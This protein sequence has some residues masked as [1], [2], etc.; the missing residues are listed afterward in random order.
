MGKKS[1]RQLALDVIEA[2]DN[3]NI[4]EPV[5]VCQQP[6]LTELEVASGALYRQG[7]RW[8]TTV[9]STLYAVVK[10]ST[11]P[12]T[13]GTWDAITWDGNGSQGVTSNLRNVSRQTVTAIIA[14][15]LVGA[16][17]NSPR[18]QQR[19]DVWNLVQLDCD[20][21][22]HVAGTTWKGYAGHIP[23]DTATITATTDP[24]HADVWAKLRWNPDAAQGN[25]NQR[26][27]AASAAGDRVV[28]VVLGT[29]AIGEI[30]QQATLH[31]CEWPRLQI[32]WE[33]FDSLQVLNDGAK[34]IDV[35]FDRRWQEGRPDPKPGIQAG[36]TT[37]QVQSP[38]CWAAGATIRVRAGLRVT[39]KST[40]DETVQIEA[41]SSIDG[42]N[43]IWATTVQVR[44]TANVGDEVGVAWVAASASLPAS[45]VQY[46]DA[47]SVEWFMKDADNATWISCGRTE[48]LLYVTFAAPTQALYWTLLDISC[49]GANG[50]MTPNAVVDGAFDPFKAQTG[51]AR[52]FKRL[53]DGVTLRYYGEG[54]NT[55]QG[56]EVQSPRGILSSAT[57][58]G[59]CGGWSR[60]MA[61]MLALHGI[62]VE[63]YTMDC[64]AL[65]ANTIFHVRNFNHN[66]A[67]TCTSLPYT[68]K[69]SECSK[70]DGL[71]GQGKTNPQFL[72]GDHAAVYYNNLIYDPS[73]GVGPEANPARYE[74]NAV[75]GLGWLGAAGND[76]TT[77]NMG[78]GTFQFKANNCCEGF[79]TQA[80]P[81]F[82]TLDNVAAAF[83]RRGIDL[84]DHP[85]NR[86]T[87][88]AGVN[89]PPAGTTLYIPRSWAPNRLMLA[90]GTRAP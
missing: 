49:R 29:P 50:K 69:G 60:L 33:E 19:V 41:R 65:A 17:L 66:G 40:D 4:E 54:A 39:R 70:P 76:F 87:K 51:D 2:Q 62:D 72:F 38:L 43:M 24:N 78:D 86:G 36:R 61:H 6:I 56:A 73:Y 83:G 67:G 52:G 58:S 79:F 9:Q 13:F 47:F 3:T 77:F 64:S 21:P 45:K 57:G 27:Y 37:H 55:A 16:T 22:I 44:S 15:R 46:A 63:L 30:R 84:W 42:V 7:D 80:M 34:Q 20:L 26:R 89:P 68:H 5:L 85:Y 8:W 75:A 90:H 71:S 81:G 31:I 82:A 10:A 59:R 32:K 53:G 23:A 48:H 1:D 14:P 18:M 88:A 35:A 25:P 11:R 74:R 28:D 12:D